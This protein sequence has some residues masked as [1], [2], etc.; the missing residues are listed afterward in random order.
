MTC[1][2]ATLRR[3]IFE[4]ADREEADLWLVNSCT[5]KSPSQS[6]MATVIQDAQR[7]GKG[8]VV[9]GCVPQGDKNARELQVHPPA[10]PALYM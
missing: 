4:E 1:H 5:V 7:L 9:A 2:S 6:A 8:L 10:A 3:L